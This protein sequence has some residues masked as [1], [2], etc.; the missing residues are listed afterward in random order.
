MFTENE[1]GLKNNTGKKEETNKE[2]SKDRKPAKKTNT[3]IETGKKP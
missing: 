2:F 1:F 3:F